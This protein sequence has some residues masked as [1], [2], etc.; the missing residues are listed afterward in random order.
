MKHP[1]GSP[2]EIS[3]IK[4]K[5]TKETDLFDGLEE[6]ADVEKDYGTKR[7]YPTGQRVL[8]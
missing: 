5:L 4:N 1:E 6:T 3:S 8:S 2:P 7:Q